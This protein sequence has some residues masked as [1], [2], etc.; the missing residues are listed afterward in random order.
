MAPWCYVQGA[1]ITVRDAYAESN[2]GMMAS[3]SADDRDT[4]SRPL[5]PFDCRLV[6][7]ASA[8]GD[9][10]WAV[11][12]RQRSDPAAKRSRRDPASSSNAIPAA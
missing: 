10:K 7:S 8:Q 3:G 9:A 2:G 4:E 6:T 5:H 1:G 12:V 11:L